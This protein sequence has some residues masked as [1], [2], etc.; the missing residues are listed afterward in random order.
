MLTDH[1]LLIG[2]FRI[3]LKRV[4]KIT[5]TKKLKKKPMQK[6]LLHLASPKTFYCKVNT[7]KWHTQR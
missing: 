1:N 6:I 2:N 3:K 7:I 4:I 5:E